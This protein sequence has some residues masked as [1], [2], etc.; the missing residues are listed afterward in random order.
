MQPNDS[1]WEVFCLISSVYWGKQYYF[2][3][4]NGMVYSRKSCNYMT[5]DDAVSEF[6]KTIGDY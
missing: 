3:Q 6:C 2:M 5:F 1:A 4:D